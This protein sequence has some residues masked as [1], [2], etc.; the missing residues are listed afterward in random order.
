VHFLRTQGKDKTMVIPSLSPPAV[1]SE[2]VLTDTAR[3]HNTK[4]C[5]CSRL[6]MGTAARTCRTSSHQQRGSDGTGGDDK[7]VQGRKIKIE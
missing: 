2:V 7:C 6:Q 1:V 5:L 3:K 4:H